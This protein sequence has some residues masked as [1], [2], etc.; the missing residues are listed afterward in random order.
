MITS[1][2]LKKLHEQ[3]IRRILSFQDDSRGSRQEP[4]PKPQLGVED[5]SYLLTQKQSS[6]QTT[7][8]LDCDKVRPFLIPKVVGPGNFKLRLYADGKIHR[9]VHTPS[10]EST[11]LGTSSLTTFH[12]EVE[13]ED[14]FEVEEILE[15]R[16]QRYL[17]KW[18]GYPHSENTWEPIQNLGNCQMILRQFRR[19]AASRRR[20]T[21]ESSRSTP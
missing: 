13:E 8:K 3:V 1:G 2:Q 18:K 20:L 10:F 21:A 7:R 19:T 5:K 14:E 15:R 11:D 9:G 12:S 17:I 16:G 4:G 6:Q